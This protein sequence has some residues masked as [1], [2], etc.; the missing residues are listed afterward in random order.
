MGAQDCLDARGGFTQKF[1]SELQLIAGE[2]L[3]RLEAVTSRAAAHDLFGV[4]R[5]RCEA[6]KESCPGYEP[7]AAACPAGSKAL[8]FPTFCQNCGCPACFHLV[9]QTGGALPEPVARSIT[10]FNI[11]QSEL[12][13]NALLAVFE[14]KEGRDCSGQV[15]ALATL[16]RSEGL[17]V[18][19]LETR[20]LDAHEALHLRSRQLHARDE[21]LGLLVSQGFDGDRARRAAEI[22]GAGK[23]QSVFSATARGDLVALE[24]EVRAREQSIRRKS[25]RL[26][27]SSNKGLG[28]RRGG[29]AGSDENFNLQNAGARASSAG[30]STF[31]GLQE[32]G[33]A[34]ADRDLAALA[35]GPG[36]QASVGPRAPNTWLQLAG[37]SLA[38]SG[39]GAAEDAGGDGLHA[40]AL[41]QLTR[42]IQ[43][44]KELARL[45][46]Q[47]HLIL[48][49]SS[50][51]Q[52]NLGDR[53]RKELVPS[54]QQLGPEPLL[55]LVYLSA[56]K[57][58]AVEDAVT[59]A[60]QLFRLQKSIILSEP[61]QPLFAP[62]TAGTGTAA[63]QASSAGGAAGRGPMPLAEWY[64]EMDR[65]QAAAAELRAELLG[66]EAK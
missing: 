33:D 24:R 45:L 49:V 37:A 2:Q 46:V 4:L 27:S 36:L 42:T 53:M 7:Q 57:I 60:P 54:F 15:S 10:G 31:E 38:L 5:R 64:E 28:E 40:R 56:S 65:A 66:A 41:T 29:A 9:V 47:P 50:A 55:S 39:Q 1:K 34:V 16:L 26:L 59:F 48:V 17:E 44:S 23:A 8:D 14:L 13:F 12:N 22:R 21:E 18:L 43:A 51:S 62:S 20:P 19:S 30:R 63:Q 58:E 61:S 3:S 6:C 32:E 25:K 35:Q 52:Q 11:R